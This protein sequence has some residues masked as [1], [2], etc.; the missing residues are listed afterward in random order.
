MKKIFALCL[1]SLTYES[2]QAQYGGFYGIQG[3]FSNFDIY[4]SRIDLDQESYAPVS[5]S[6]LGIF[7][8]GPAQAAIDPARKWY[9]TFDH[10]E[11]WNSCLYTIDMITGQTLFRPR[12]TDSAEIPMDTFFAGFHYCTADS[13]LYGVIWGASNA[14]LVK[15]N[16]ETLQT[17]TI[18]VLPI[19]A[20]SYGVT[21]IADRDENYFFIAGDDQHGDNRLL[22]INRLTGQ[23]EKNSLLDHNGDVAGYFLAYDCNSNKIYAIKDSYAGVQSSL[24]L[25]EINPDNGAQ[26]LLV[27]QSFDD[28]VM[29]VPLV[30]TE[31]GF[32]Y[33][34]GST[35]NE[36]MHVHKVNLSNN[37]VETNQF[38]NF[39]GAFSM[40]YLEGITAD[41]IFNNTCFGVKTQFTN[42]SGGITFSWNFGD[43]ATGN[44]NTSEE[45]NPGHVF[46]SPG[47]YDV[48]LVAES[49]SGIDTVIKHIVIDPF[50]EVFIRSDTT[51]CS[52][53]PVSLD[54]HADYPGYQITW[55]DGSGNTIYHVSSPGIYVL[56]VSAACGYS[57]D[58]LNVNGIEC[59]CDEKVFP[60]PSLFYWNIDLGC[61]ISN[62]S[63]PSFSLF[64]VLG[65]KIMNE[66]LLDNQS[67]YLQ[68]SDLA[69]GTYFFRLKDQKGTL[70]EGKLMVIK[71]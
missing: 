12:F 57:S 56:T 38:N 49:C 39:P 29:T 47:E 59:P 63:N 53:N 15:V 4:L 23:V 16:Y 37:S 30:K 70:K 50:P 32:L 65:R 19:S 64:D 3:L 34:I 51:V 61:D 31:T 44:E 21:L 54:L 20:F 9:F 11:H 27:S 43:E 18:C 48:E 13:S 40:A 10:D 42:L 68:F 58:S 36:G 26:T 46:S 33:F 6:S 35:N 41:F 66:I 14:R 67:T 25:Y 1:L 60:N 45:R 5:S 2:A 8:W 7:Y 24:L 52:N 17:T 55:Q 69:S 28:F 71:Y 62:F 22:K